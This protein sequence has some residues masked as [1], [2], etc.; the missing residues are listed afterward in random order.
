MHCLFCKQD[1]TDS[2]S[3]EHII[4]ESLGNTT[5]LLPKGVVCDKCNNYFARKVEQPFL[6]SIDIR[7]LRFREALPNKRGI[8]PSLDGIFSEGI[9]VKVYNPFPGIPLFA[10]K[11]DVI[12]SINPE[13][14]DSTRIKQHGSIIT[15]A[16]TDDMIPQNTTIIS[17]FIAK[18]AFESL[19]ERL[20]E[21][22][23]GLDHLVDAPMYDPIRDYVRLGNIENW[24]CNI[25]RIYGMDKLWQDDMGI[26]QQI[27]HERD[28]L[29]IPVDESSDLLNDDSVLV[30]PYF[31]FALFGL[32]FV[33]YIAD[34]DADGLDPYKTWLQKNGNVS[35]LYFG[36]NEA[37]R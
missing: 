17:R 27:V 2:K 19:A 18:V 36:K 20:S 12:V 37:K 15:P 9:S 13:H 23:G 33:I 3:V 6:K 31:V 28:F 14:A 4:P 10:R 8:I 16:F 21:H 11:T 35:P 30:Y 7:T 5:A 29:L 24:P 32:E 22:D 26:Q 34:P 25:R 1:S